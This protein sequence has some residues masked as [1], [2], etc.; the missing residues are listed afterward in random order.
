MKQ[1]NK[2]T[3]FKRSLLL[4]KDKKNLINQ[5][6]DIEIMS[7]YWIEKITGQ[8]VDDEYYSMKVEIFKELL[9]KDPDYKRKE[10]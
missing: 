7:Y 1:V 4:G 6:M 2:I 10:K 3:K 9:E 8:K 5:L